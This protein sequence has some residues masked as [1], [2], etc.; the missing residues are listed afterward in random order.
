MSDHCFKLGQL[1]RMSRGFSDRTG[2]GNYEILRLL[3]GS[4]DGEL[5][6]RVKGSDKIER[7]VGE[8]QLLIAKQ[9]LS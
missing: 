2:A 8:S 1:V 6:Y 7:A 9:Q 3:P 5:H 4:V